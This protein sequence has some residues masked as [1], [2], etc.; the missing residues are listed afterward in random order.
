[1]EAVMLIFYRI[2]NWTNIAHLSL[3]HGLFGLTEL[4]SD[5]KSTHSLLK[6]KSGALW[7]NCV[8]L[9]SS[10]SRQWEMHF[11]GTKIQKMFS[12]EWDLC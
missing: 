6:S 5:W 2:K 11:L 3:V 7:C 4:F 10:H 9:T 1:M 8:I 12:N